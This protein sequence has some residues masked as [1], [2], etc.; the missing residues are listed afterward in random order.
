MIIILK[1]F[2][3]LLAKLGGPTAFFS[4]DESTGWAFTSMIIFDHFRKKLIFSF[5]TN[6]YG[7]IQSYLLELKQPVLFFVELIFVEEHKT[8]NEN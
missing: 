6:L 1:S 4:G 2:F 7:G 5:K 3:Y 8:Q